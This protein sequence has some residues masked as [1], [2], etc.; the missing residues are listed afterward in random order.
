MKRVETMKE[1]LYLL[2]LSWFL[3]VIT[4]CTTV[5]SQL[6]APQP[7]TST[8]DQDILTLVKTSVQAA[9][10]AKKQTPGPILHQIDTDLKT[11]TFRFTDKGATRE[12][13]VFI[14]AIGIPP[15]Q[16]T[17]EVNERTPLVGNTT[18]GLNL[19]RLRF[20]PTYVAQ[21]V[22]RHWQ[23]CTL[24]SLT[25]YSENDHLTWVAFCNT[26]EGVIT[27]TLNGESGVFTPS[28]AP[29]AP[30]PVTATPHP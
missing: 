24:R 29:P 18:P 2:V 13:T 25:L 20:G 27:G 8:P 19:D 9:Q 23:G 12:I 16:W 22:F 15:E 28:D 11:M 10:I 30:L 1:L 7:I 26:A 3:I 17:T 6:L 21:M 14:P 5:P 4:A